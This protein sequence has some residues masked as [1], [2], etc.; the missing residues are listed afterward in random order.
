[1]QSINLE[2]LAAAPVDEATKAAIEEAQASARRGETV[3]LE[4]SN[5]NLEKRLK[6]WRQIQQAED[7]AA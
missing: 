1:M 6:A 5:I 3:T 4:Q 2:E 7:L